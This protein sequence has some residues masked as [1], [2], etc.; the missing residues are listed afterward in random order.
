MEN[1]GINKMC[2]KRSKICS[3]CNIEKELSFFYKDK[4]GKNGLAASCKE[5]FCVKQ[6]KYIKDNPDKVRESKKK[7]NKI[8][9]DLNKEK[10]L[11]KS[12]IYR[13]NN[14]EKVAERHK[15]YREENPEK[16][17]ESQ[18][19]CKEKNPDSIKES[20]K[21]WRKAN[22][23]IVNKNYKVYRK[24]NPHIIVCRNILRHCLEHFNKKK[25]LETKTNDLL[26]YSALELK[27]HMITLFTK[28][29]SWDNHG[30]WHIDHIKPVSK[31]DKDTPMN[32][33]NALSNLRPL[34]A[35][36]REIN[37]IIYEGNLNRPKI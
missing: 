2:D 30:E 36:T 34:W 20:N 25:G 19:K 29:M 21:K 22:S 12:R 9:Y 24:K 26:G 10:F 11:E 33:V 17:K 1:S 5:C 16:I 4:R 32:I 14:P 7:S 27:N 8:N 3:N 31:F 13:E 6:K 15:S 35:T 23:D 18:R 28:G 37:G